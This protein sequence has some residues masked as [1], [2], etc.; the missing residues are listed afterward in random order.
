MQTTE[1]RGE[2]AVDERQVDAALE[3]MSWDSLGPAAVGLAG[4][5]AFF[6]VGH[7]LAPAAVEARTSMSAVRGGHRR[8]VRRL[9]VAWHRGRIAR[10]RSR[11]WAVAI[12][13]LVLANALV[14]L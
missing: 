1:G 12:A 2:P 3:A 5:F 14:H 9:R 8:R 7:L 13:L 4:L 6:A 10:G 11:A